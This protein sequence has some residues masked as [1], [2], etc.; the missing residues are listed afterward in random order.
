MILVSWVK[1]NQLSKKKQ[2]SNFNSFS[3]NRSEKASAQLIISNYKTHQLSEPEQLHFLDYATEQLTM[4]EYLE[5]EHQHRNGH[6]K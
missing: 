3:P 4:R 6:H 1:D 2:G 5:K